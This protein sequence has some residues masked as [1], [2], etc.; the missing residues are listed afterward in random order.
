[1]FKLGPEMFKWGW[2]RMGFIMAITLL[3]KGSITFD[4]AIAL[5]LLAFIAESRDSN[6]PTQGKER[7]GPEK[8]RQKQR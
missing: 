2:P 5:V 6:G 7:K 1:M 3:L 8:S 4:Q